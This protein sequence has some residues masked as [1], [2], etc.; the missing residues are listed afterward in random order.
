MKHC[1]P[2]VQWGHTLPH[3]VTTWQSLFHLYL[4]LSKRTRR[5][6]QNFYIRINQ[7]ENVSPVGPDLY[8]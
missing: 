1:G 8:L 2:E 4:F 6:L 5:P 3:A 7:L